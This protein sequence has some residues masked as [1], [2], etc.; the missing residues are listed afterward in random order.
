MEAL[1]WY[2]KLVHIWLW[3]QT[4]QKVSISW[5]F[6]YAYFIKE[7]DLEKGMF[8]ESE[9]ICDSQFNKEPK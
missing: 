2:R 9:E 1:F 8:M 4:L 3:G 6:L 5:M 7:Q